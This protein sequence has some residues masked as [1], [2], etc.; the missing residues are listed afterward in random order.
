MTL[1]TDPA[2]VEAMTE[3]YEPLHA[4]FQSLV[5]PARG[6]HGAGGD[7]YPSPFLLASSRAPTDTGSVESVGHPGSTD[8]PGRS[9]S[10]EFPVTAKHGGARSMHLPCFP[11]P[12]S[13]P[14]G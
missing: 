2:S 6:R 10:P 4:S 14:A 8:A 3:G 11:L 5:P 1:P 13:S 7:L 12:S 9:Q